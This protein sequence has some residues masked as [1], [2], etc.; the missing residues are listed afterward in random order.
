MQMPAVQRAGGTAAGRGELLGASP[1]GLWE[2]ESGLLEENTTLLVVETF[3][4]PPLLGTLKI[5]NILFYF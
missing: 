3:L 1:R 2:R 5:C 4:Y